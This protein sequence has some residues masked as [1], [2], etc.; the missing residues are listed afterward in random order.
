MK[1]K[2]QIDTEFRREDTEKHREISANLRAP[3]VLLCVK[4]Y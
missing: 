1:V 4:F 2:N 3:S